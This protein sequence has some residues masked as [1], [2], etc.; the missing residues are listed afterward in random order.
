MTF[1]P[2]RK[3]FHLL[4]R[5]SDL[6]SLASSKFP[7][8][9]SRRNPP[10]SR[11]VDSRSLA[12]LAENLSRAPRGEGESAQMTASVDMLAEQMLAVVEIV[13][14]QEQEIRALKEQCQRLEEHEQAIMV[15][16]TTFFHVLAAGHIAS[17]NEISSILRNITDIAEEE[18]RPREAIH[19][20]QNLADMLLNQSY[21]SADDNGEHEQS[22]GDKDD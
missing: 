15:A 21:R 11:L 19:F 1:A 5:L 20:L 17:L 14:A 18:G 13:S 7:L 8:L 4:T 16:F 3:L 2:I 6:P 12:F 9:F 10:S 22:S